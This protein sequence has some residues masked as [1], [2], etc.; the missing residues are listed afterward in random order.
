MA[1]FKFFYLAKFRFCRGFA[2]PSIV[3]KRK[4]SLGSWGESG[5]KFIAKAYS[6]MATLAKRG[7]SFARYVRD[8]FQ[9]EMSGFEV[10]P[11]PS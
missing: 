6:I 10:P 9:S 4:V 8:V 3:L 2:T 7:V 5:E 11:L 1:F